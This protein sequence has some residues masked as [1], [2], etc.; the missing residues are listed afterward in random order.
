MDLLPHIPRSPFKCECGNDQFRCHGYVSGN[1]DVVYRDNCTEEG[2]IVEVD[3]S[4]LESDE[5]VIDI[6]GPF[7]C[8][9]CRKEY[10]EIPPSGWTGDAPSTPLIH[11]DDELNIFGGRGEVQ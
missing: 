10:K 11:T 5:N 9:K 6:E 8:T 3:S 4:S 2:E 1:V 7:H